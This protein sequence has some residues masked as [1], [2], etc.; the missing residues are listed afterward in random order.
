MEGKV[1]GSKTSPPYI[2]QSLLKNSLFIRQ[3][4]SIANLT[5]LKSKVDDDVLQWDTHLEF[6]QELTQLTRKGIDSLQA[7]IDEGNKKFGENACLY[8]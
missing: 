8:L 5:P 7:K 4:P 2:Q 3:T 6:N 1:S